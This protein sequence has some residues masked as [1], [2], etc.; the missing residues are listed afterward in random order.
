MQ[1]QRCNCPFVSG[2]REWCFSPMIRP[3]SLWRLGFWPQPTNAILDCEVFRALISQAAFSHEAIF[4]YFYTFL[5]PGTLLIHS[6]KPN[7]SGFGC[8]LSTGWPTNPK[9]SGTP[10]GHRFVVVKVPRRQ[11]LRIVCGKTPLKVEKSDAVWRR[12]VWMDYCDPLAENNH[13]STYTGNI[14]ALGGRASERLKLILNIFCSL[15][16]LKNNEVLLRETF[17]IASKL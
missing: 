5:G 13:L 2:I 8:L 1:K 16:L 12:W 6:C 9:T 10:R 7:Q 3:T 17:L 15:Q 4:C 11:R 14:K